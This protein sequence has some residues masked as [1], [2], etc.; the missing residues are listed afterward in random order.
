MKSNVTNLVT[1]RVTGQEATAI[2]AALKTFA[3]IP[4]KGDVDAN[5]LAEKIV[6][7]ITKPAKKE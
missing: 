1:I 4:P 5:A 6:E 2:V 3:K 7:Q